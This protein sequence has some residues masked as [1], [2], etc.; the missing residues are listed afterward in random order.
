LLAAALSGLDVDAASAIG[1]RVAARLRLSRELCAAIDA[2]RAEGHVVWLASASIDHVVAAVGR[3]VGAHGA[4]ATELADDG[5]LLTGRYRG[6]NCKGEEKVRRLDEVLPAGWREQAVAYS[7]SRADRPL[8]DAVAE[9]RWVRRG[10]LR[11]A[12]DPSGARR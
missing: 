6:R 4:V 10:R 1:D 7:D 5:G 12:P 3:R 11:P 8:M 2:H 9:A